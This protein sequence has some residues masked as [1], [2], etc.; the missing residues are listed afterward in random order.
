MR[1]FVT[2]AVLS[3][4]L[5]LS[6]CKKDGDS[7]DPSVVEGISGDVENEVEGADE[8]WDKT[9]EDVEGAGE[10]IADAVSSDEEEGAEGDAEG[11]EEEAAE[12]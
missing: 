7:N 10:D 8:T 1:T 11:G 5:A 9:V 12:E 6:A 4:P 3:L 2:I